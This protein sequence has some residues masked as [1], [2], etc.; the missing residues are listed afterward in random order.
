MTLM[1]NGELF[2]TK[3]KK[4][5]IQFLLLGSDEVIAKINVDIEPILKSNHQVDFRKEYENS[6]NKHFKFNNKLEQRRA[7]KWQ[8]LKEKEKDSVS[9]NNQSQEE[10]YLINSTLEK[11][12]SD[13]HSIRKTSNVKKRNPNFSTEENVTLPKTTETFYVIERDVDT[14]ALTQRE[15]ENTCAIPASSENISNFV[16][17]N[18]HFRKKSEAKK[19]VDEYAQD[20]KKKRSY[21]D[22]VNS[23]HVNNINLSDIYLHLLMSEENNSSKTDTSPPHVCTNFAQI[24][25]HSR[26]LE[27]ESDTLLSTQDKEVLSILEEL[28]NKNDMSN[29]NSQ[30]SRLTGHFCSNT[31]F[32]L[33]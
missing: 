19:K 29:I 24:L 11:P 1:I 23:T 4:N 9:S 20:E 27:E 22:P 2:Y 16:T 18:R 26:S 13:N 6:E 12:A 14:D 15:K 28:E 3:Q 7:E 10:K 17:D 30:I 5:L 32:N 31:V 8:K 21:A 25:N 33:S